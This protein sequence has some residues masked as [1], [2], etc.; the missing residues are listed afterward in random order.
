MVS[1]F[2]IVTIESRKNKEISLYSDYVYTKINY[3]RLHSK[4]T[5]VTRK[6]LGLQKLNRD[7]ELPMS[8]RLRWCIVLLD[9]SLPRVLARYK[10]AFFFLF[11]LVASMCNFMNYFK[12][13]FLNTHACA[14]CSRRVFAETSVE[15]GSG[16]PGK[17]GNIF[18]GSDP[19]YKLSGS[20]PDWIT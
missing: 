11:F 8:R 4:Q 14:N 10:L 17:P 13:D 20:D 6:P 18:S 9:L 7:F 1:I 16:H 5:H 12:F 3:R 15:T 2:G 19:V